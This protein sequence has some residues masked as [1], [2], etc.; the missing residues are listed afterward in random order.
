MSIE[1]LRLQ[2]DQLLGVAERLGWEADVPF[3]KLLAETDTLKS[4]I[5]DRAQV[6]KM[7]ADD[8][9]PGG[10]PPERRQA[11]VRHQRDQVRNA[12]KG[13]RTTVLCALRHHLPPSLLG[14]FV[15]RLDQ[16]D[17]DAAVFVLSSGTAN[18]PVF[19]FDEGNRVSLNGRTHELTDEQYRI[20]KMIVDGR[21][22]SIP[23][24]ELKKYPTSME[25]PERAIAKLPED[26]AKTIERIRGRGFRL[27]ELV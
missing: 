14:P 9:C 23:S 27:L 11:I 25:R 19:H 10:S 26:L 2:L 6:Q 5:G 22:R 21:G 1:E 13:L 15:E 7:I 16:S 3:R 20:V 12:Y 8:V 24:R 17:D 4:Q 18:Y